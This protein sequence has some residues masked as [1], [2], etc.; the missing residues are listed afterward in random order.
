MITLAFV[1]E[2]TGYIYYTAL[3]GGQH[4]VPSRYNWGVNVRLSNDMPL[5]EQLA[6]PTQSESDKP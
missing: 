2:A 4:E 3:A 5:Q 1:A 6:P